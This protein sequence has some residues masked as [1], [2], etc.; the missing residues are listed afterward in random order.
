M[1][2]APFFLVI[3]G[4][5]ALSAFLVSAGGPQTERQAPKPELVILRGTVTELGPYLAD[6]FQVPMDNDLGKAT[7]ALVTD[8]GTVHP[9]IKDMRSRGFF[10]DQ[11]LRDRPMEL[12]VHR[13]A[14]LPYVRVIDV[15]SFKDGR[16]HK[17][18]Y[19]CAVCAISTFQ[20]GPCPCCQDEIELRELP[21][22]E[23]LT[24]EPR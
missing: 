19:W 20:G 11:R 7:L 9:L 3:L 14:G 16:K 8:S 2:R 24:A 12:H 17:V 23:A 4:S 10:L 6:A 15:Y 13:Y 21:V 1:V 22:E 5:A 18:D